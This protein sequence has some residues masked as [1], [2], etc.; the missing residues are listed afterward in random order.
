MTP[1]RAARS[2]DSR[3]PIVAALRAAG[4]SVEDLG[5]PVDLLVGYRGRDFLIDCKTDKAYR[6]KDGYQ[7][8]QKGRAT[9]A[10]ERF[11]KSHKGS[12]VYFVRNAE[13]AVALVIHGVEPK[14][15]AA[16]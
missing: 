4:A 11:A 1:R 8:H 10:Q 13:E 12:K 16:A 15:E 2:D 5:Y 9:A 3:G 6:G 14:V 7:H